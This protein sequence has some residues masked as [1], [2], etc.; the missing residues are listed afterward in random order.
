MRFQSNRVIC[1]RKDEKECGKKTESIIKSFSN[2]TGDSI[3]C[4][5]KPAILTNNTLIR[6]SKALNNRRPI[7]S[8]S[9]TISSQSTNN[10]TGRSDRDRKDKSLKDN[11]QQRYLM[12]SG[13]YFGTQGVT[14]VCF[15]LFISILQKKSSCLLT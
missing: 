6:G 12:D 11:I 14:F 13:N 9:S 10:E 3:F 1:F 4:A 15:G 2:S 7:T 5:G 8:S